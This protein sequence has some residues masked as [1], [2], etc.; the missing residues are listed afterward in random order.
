MN[1]GRGKES[2][3][4]EICEKQNMFV[5]GGGLQGRPK[6]K[7]KQVACGLGG[8]IKKMGHIPFKPIGLQC[9]FICNQ[10]LMWPLGTLRTDQ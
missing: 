7:A 4:L 6:R 3:V 9:I 8:Q 1:V 2:W 5:S 10:I